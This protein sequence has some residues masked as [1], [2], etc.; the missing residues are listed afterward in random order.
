MQVT[1]Y[2]PVTSRPSAAVSVQW[3]L[4]SSHEAP[5]TSKPNTMS[6]R[7]SNRLATWFRYP[8]VSGCGANRS[9][10]L[11]SCSRSGEKR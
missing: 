11:Q 6:G 2:R 7:R 1:R 3:Q 9:C 5:V 10:Q 8:S 4:A